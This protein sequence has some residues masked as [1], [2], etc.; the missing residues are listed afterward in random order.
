MKPPRPLPRL[1]AFIALLFLLYFSTNC[2]I[3]AQAGGGSQ[4]RLS[5]TYTVITRDSYG[6]T[7]N[8]CVLSVIDTSTSEV[9]ATST[10]PVSSCKYNPPSE[11][12]ERTETF[13]LGCGGFSASQAG[14][15]YNEECS[16]I[17][18]DSA[19]STVAEASGTSG[20]IFYTLTTCSSCELGSGSTS[21]T[22]C[23]TCLAG[24]YS[25]VDGP[26]SCKICEAGK[27]R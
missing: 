3:F 14:S 11:T 19:G 5:E 18:K 6:D 24:K 12:C 13:T 16:W 17:I 22:D 15:E 9:V 26:G 21:E 23:E 7:W 25:D 27:Y 4:R 8:G 2:F 10:G 1:K 20:A